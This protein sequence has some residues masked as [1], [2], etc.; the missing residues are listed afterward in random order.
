MLIARTIRTALAVLPVFFLLVPSHEARAYKFTVLYTFEGGKDGTAPSGHLTMDTAGNVYGTTEEGGGSG[1]PGALG[2]AYVLSPDGT[3][4]IVLA[5]D[6]DDGSMPESGLVKDSSGNLYGT[7]AEGGRSGVHTRCRKILEYGC[8]VVFKLTTAGKETV[9]HVF[10]QQH[11]WS[12]SGRIVVDDAGNIFGTTENGGQCVSSSRYG[13]GTVYK[14]KRNGRFEV[15]YAF[16]GAADGS[17]P[18]GG[19][20]EDKAGNLYGTTY[21]GGSSACPSGCG[22]VFEVTQAGVE[23]VLYSFTGGTDGANPYASLVLDNAG[24]L[25]G[26]TEFGGAFGLG[27]VFKL[28][29]AG[30]ETILH[31]FAGGSGD[32][33]YPLA[34]VVRDASGNLYGTTFSGGGTACSG[35]GCGTAFELTSGGA[36]NVLHEFTD[37]SD[38]ALPNGPLNIDAAGN[39]YG[40]A[41]LGQNNGGTVFKLTP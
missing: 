36:E 23:T 28:S 21:A 5:F 11:G 17:G 31:S 8:G 9:L 30:S 4:K 12:P 39:L 26:T 22:T 19:L 38:G 35:E 13:C 29:P 25:Y 41:S 10:G 27:T 32:G 6:G 40:T 2:T 24:N 3:E 14:L 1:Y 7:T 16:K 33:A 15:I 34:P 37:G 20:I 18:E